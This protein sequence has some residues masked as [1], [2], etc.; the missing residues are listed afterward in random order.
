VTTTAAQVNAVVVTDTTLAYTTSL[1]AQLHSV[2]AAGGTVSTLT[3][4]KLSPRS[5]YQLAA[6]GTNVYFATDGNLGT[7]GIAATP[8]AATTPTAVATDGNAPLRSFNIALTAG[9][10]AWTDNR[11]ANHPVWSRSLTNANGI[12]AGAQSLVATNATF[13]GLSI[14]ATRTA[15]SSGNAV[16]VKRGTVSTK[17]TDVVPLDPYLLSGTRIAYFANSGKYRVRNLV[18]GTTTS[19]SLTH[20]PADRQQLSLFGNY[21]AYVKPDGSVW[22]KDLTTT[23]A[24]VKMAGAL[25]HFQ[26]G[27]VV[28]WGDWVGWSRWTAS[29][30]RNGFRNARTMSA[31]TTLPT[32]ISVVSASVGGF[33]YQTSSGAYRYRRWTNSTTYALPSSHRAVLWIYSDTGIAPPEVSGSRMAWIGADGRPRVA[34]LPVHVADRPRSLGNARA[35]HALQLGATWSF[36]LV[37]SATLSQCAV[38]IQNSSGKTIRTLSCAKAAAQQGEIE[39]SWD[40]KN[41]SGHRVRAGSYTWLVAAGNS[42]GALVN[43]NGSTHPTKGTIEVS[44]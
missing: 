17:L 11:Q 31:I 2:P 18:T 29:G 40:G 4:P 27:Y 14:S 38:K 23:A 10:A 34:P 35:R 12:T 9:R 44:S 19:L 8:D 7:A 42:D 20:V 28:T 25:S 43:A 15:Y 26:F 30:A 32:T 22:R 24:P 33:T 41:A 16:F 37:T 21:V 1:D 3:S 13:Y 6:D 39:A 5:D 36:D